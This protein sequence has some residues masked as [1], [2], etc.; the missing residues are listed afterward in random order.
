MFNLQLILQGLYKSRYNWL[1]E[2]INKRSKFQ[3]GC[4]AQH[5]YTSIFDC[6]NVSIILEAG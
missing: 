1:L 5:N 3:I 2:K 4:G 6:F